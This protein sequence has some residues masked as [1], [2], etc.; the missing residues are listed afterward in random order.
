MDSSSSSSL[1]D[2]SPRTVSSLT[3]TST[4]SVNDYLLVSQLSGLDYYSKKATMAT[5]ASA[6]A[7]SVLNEAVDTLCYPLFAVD[8]TGTL[9]PKTN[10]GLTFNSSTGALD[11]T[12]I[13]TPTISSSAAIA[14]TPASGSGI[15][16]NLATTG[17]FAV[18]TNQLYVDTSTGRVGIGTTSPGY[19]LDAAGDARFS[20]LRI[21]NAVVGLLTYDGGA[22]NTLNVIGV[23][24]RSLS[25]GSNAVYDRMLIDTKGN[26][27]IGTIT[28]TAN[29]Q[30]AQSTVGVGTVTITGNTTCTGTGTQFTNTFKVGDNIII[31]ATGETRAISVITSNTVMTIASAT[32]TVGSAYTLAGGTRFSVLGNGNVG[33]GTTA[34]DYKFDIRGA[35]GSTIINVGGATNATIFQVGADASGDGF[36]YVKDSTGV[37]KIVLDADSNSYF[38]NGNVGI[39][40]TS[41]GSKLSIIG[42]GA[43]GLT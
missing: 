9:A 13:N 22:T 35:D 41:P 10:S 39:G 29:L 3:E 7:V 24:G 31:T 30:V 15:N 32:N 33:I 8:A 12:S 38:N 5:L 14:L 20:S 28:P 25:F 18:N 23:T 2:L 17:D 26:V 19:L 34:P 43:G 11:A 21:G 1:V 6:L 4:L 40:T 27:G 16:V 36:L 37:A 42:V